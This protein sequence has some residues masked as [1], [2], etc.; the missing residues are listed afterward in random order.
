[1][2]L[3]LFIPSFSSTFDFGKVFENAQRL[4][5]LVQ[6]KKITLFVLGM[7][8]FTGVF[9]QEES[10]LKQVP[11]V[12][13]KDLKGN[14]INTAALG[15]EGPVVISFWATWCAPCKK[16]LNTIHD[17][18][19]DWQ[20]ETGVNLVA[21]SIDDEKTLNSVPLY[22]NG[23][24]WEYLVLSDPNGDFKRAMGVNTVPHTFLIDAEGN[25]VYTHNNYAPGDEEK[26]YEE[27]KKLGAK[28]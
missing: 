7:A 26:L 24:G 21:V 12:Q 5:K 2:I 1:M 11:S 25:I 9:A 19:T 22:V 3:F 8:L 18:Y 20:E 16:E 10:T 27:I 6:M 13:L 17:L 23:R 4:K 15:F 28:K 14:T